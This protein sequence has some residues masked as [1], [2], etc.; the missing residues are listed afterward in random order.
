[1]LNKE[2][3]DT[4]DLCIDNELSVHFEEVKNECIPFSREKEYLGCCV[5]ANLS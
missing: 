3:G 5:D 1:M 4:C 2:F